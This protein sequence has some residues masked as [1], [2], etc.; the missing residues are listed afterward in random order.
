MHACIENR[1]RENQGQLLICAS[2]IHQLSLYR[3]RLCKEKQKIFC[4]FIF[5][6]LDSI[7]GIS[8]PIINNYRKTKCTKDVIIYQTI[9]SSEHRLSDI[10]NIVTGLYTLGK[11]YLKTKQ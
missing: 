6:F 1:R 9:M 3:N 4:I 7:N 8:S 11:I 5:L 10:R 2:C